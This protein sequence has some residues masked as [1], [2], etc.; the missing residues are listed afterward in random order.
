MEYDLCIIGAGAAGITIAR[1]FVDSRVR[2]G[3][4]ESGGLKPDRETLSLY[5]GETSET[6]PS[7][8]Q[9]LTTSRVRYFGRTQREYQVGA[10]K[11][12]GRAQG[13]TGP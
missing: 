13:G 12:T 2:V 1:E 11:I 8:F 10:A 9:Y 6:I 5:E 4:I 3:L 7:S